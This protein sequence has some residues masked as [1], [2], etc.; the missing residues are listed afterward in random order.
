VAKAL[1]VPRKR[2]PTRP[3]AGS[4]EARLLVKKRLARLKKTRS[5]PGGDD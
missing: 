3:T 4:R 1:V 5:A 2:R